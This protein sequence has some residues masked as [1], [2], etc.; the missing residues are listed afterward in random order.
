MT[1]LGFAGSLLVA[2]LACAGCGGEDEAPERFSEGYNAAIKR[3]NEVN[4]NLRENGRELTSRPGS[5]IAKEFDR[6]AETAARTRASLARLEPP[7]DARE[8]FDRLLA[9]IRG[10]V[11]DIRAVARA[12]RQENQE[13]FREAIRALSESGAAVSEAERR[14]KEA[15]GAG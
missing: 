13:R 10:G 1:R 4:T 9:E 3:L 6:I 12:A 7:E 5:E 8:E 14:L 11:E 2:A 15:V